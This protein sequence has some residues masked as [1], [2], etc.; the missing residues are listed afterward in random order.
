MAEI[1]LHT[2]GSEPG[3]LY[4]SRSDRM[5]TGVC[6]GIGKHYNIDPTIVRIIFAILALGWLTGLLLYIIL[7]VV[8]P[9]EP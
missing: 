9:E 7:S 8:I 5:L 1:P 4:R 2:G 6:G 3:R